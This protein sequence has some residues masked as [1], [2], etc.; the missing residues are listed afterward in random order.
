MNNFLLFYFNKDF[1]SVKNINSLD[2]LQS[3]VAHEEDLYRKKNKK[4]FLKQKLRLLDYS[5]KFSKD[6]TTN[7][8]FLIFNKIFSLKLPSKTKKEFIIK[9]LNLY[10]DLLT[11]EEILLFLTSFW[12][13]NGSTWHD[14]YFLFSTWLKYLNS[15]VLEINEKS[16]ELIWFQD[17]LLNINTEKKLMNF[18]MDLKDFIKLISLPYYLLSES[19]S[20]VNKKPDHFKDEEF[21]ISEKIVLT[22]IDQ[23]SKNEITLLDNILIDLL[24]YL[25]DT[26]NI[27]NLD[28]FTSILRVNLPN[29]TKK[30]QPL[31]RRVLY[32]IHQIWQKRLISYS[33]FLEFTYYVGKNIGKMRNHLYINHIIKLQ[34][35]SFL[36][37]N[38]MFELINDPK[39]TSFMSYKTKNKLFQSFEAHPEIFIDLKFL[40]FYLNLKKC[41]VPFINNLNNYYFVIF[42]NEQA[43]QT[44]ISYFIIQPYKR[45]KFYINLMIKYLKSQ[46]YAIQFDNLSDL[47]F[48]SLEKATQ[49]ALNISNEKIKY[50]IFEKLLILNE[51]DERFAPLVPSLFLSFNDV[52]F[53]ENFRSKMSNKFI[54]YISKLNP[55]TM[56]A[57]YYRMFLRDTY[58]IVLNNDI[59]FKHK[60]SLADKLNSFLEAFISY[61]TNL[62][63]DKEKMEFLEYLTTFNLSP[64]PKKIIMRWVKNQPNLNVKIISTIKDSF[65]KSQIISDLKG[66][67]NELVLNDVKCG[68]CL[69]EITQTQ[70]RKSCDTCEITLCITCFI[71]FEF[72]GDNCPGSIYGNKLHKFK[73]RKE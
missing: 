27:T 25:V 22:V 2:E 53:N 56:N 10:S 43:W 14:F 63:P 8:L 58:K 69:R 13:I 46:Q 62:I 24:C 52:I 59:S 40:K 9:V 23:F 64:D 44:F 66:S 72:S 42:N 18:L 49:L 31:V 20:Y 29:W 45:K 33:H 1:N 34:Q 38:Q 3:W 17:A 73:I 71:E 32:F 48:E 5:K 65:T 28:E 16:I 30:S 55:L 57:N 50:I 61:R 68:S 41:L 21:V 15:E 26:S 12:H 35:Q 4:K 67:T 36:Q 54:S 6:E 11:N 51:N 19:L 60:D 47:F 39:I 37:I 70:D 7:E